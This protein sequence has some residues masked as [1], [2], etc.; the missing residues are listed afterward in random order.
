VYPLAVVEIIEAYHGYQPPAD[1]RVLVTDLLATVPTPQLLGL[2]RVVL[3]NSAALTGARKRARS[4]ARGRKVRHA[5]EAAGLYHQ[6]WR[7]E[8]AWIEVFVDRVH[9]NVPKPL[10]RLAFVRRNLLGFVLYHEL[11][12]HLHQTQRPEHR[13]RESVA[14]DWGRKLLQAHLRARHPLAMTVLKP[15]ARVGRWAVRR[16]RR[17]RST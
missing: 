4:R 15:V 14:D 8:P 17:S 7:G 16:R 1:T 11:G 9:A 2:A 12:H 10:L 3:T 13:E 6:E 5:T